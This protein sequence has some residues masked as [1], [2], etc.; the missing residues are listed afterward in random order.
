[1]T[2]VPTTGATDIAETMKTKGTMKA[3]NLFRMKSPKLPHGIKNKVAWLSVILL[4]ACQGNTVYH[5]Y[6][7]VPIDGW[8][9]DDT[10]IYALPSSIP[11][12]TYEIEIGIRYQIS[13]PYRN[14]ALGISHNMRD[15]LI[16]TTDT[17]QIF[18][19][20]ETDSNTENGI[21]G[22]YQRTFT[23]KTHLSIS[24]KGETRTFR[25]VQIMRDNPLKGINDVGIQIKAIP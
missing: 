7:A 14:L 18:L 17:L 21:G 4:T 3:T 1:M 9:K 8:R 20:S 23:Y 2:A 22:L 6:Q 16:Y 5:S 13:Y 15:T 10:L 25:I 19:T 11:I 12:R 24:Q